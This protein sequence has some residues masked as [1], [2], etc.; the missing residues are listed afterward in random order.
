MGGLPARLT[1][2]QG[3]VECR[4]SSGLLGLTLTG[5]SA[6]RPGEELEL[7][8]AAAAPADLPPRLTDALIERTGMDEYRIAAQG[9]DW[10]LTA[11]ALHVHRNVGRA[12]YRAIPGRP[13]P[14]AR[15]LLYRVLLV[16]ARSR[17]GLM[18]LRALRR[19]AF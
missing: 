11:R 6:E 10:R 14:R 18:L 7:A 2:F 9:R 5:R 19:S 13:A 16:L 8:F 15:R 3:E 1:Q 12:F 17:A 4:R